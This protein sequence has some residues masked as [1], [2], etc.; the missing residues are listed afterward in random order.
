MMHT[1][2]PIILRYSR[3]AFPDSSQ[4]MTLQRFIDLGPDAC[5]LMGR[6]WGAAHT[7]VTF[8]YTNRGY[9]T[10]VAPVR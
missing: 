3:W 10:F 9:K 1:T 7:T 2:M 5:L 8:Q 6:V 4:V